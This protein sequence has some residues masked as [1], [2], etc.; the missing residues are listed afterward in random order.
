LLTLL[1]SDHS[2]EVNNSLTRILP[3]L[4]KPLFR[5]LPLIISLMAHLIFC[6]AS[7]LSGSGPP[8]TGEEPVPP[9]NPNGG[10]DQGAPQQA[11]GEDIGIVPLIV[12]LFVVF[13]IVLP[14]IRRGGGGGCLLPF[15]FSGGGVTFGGGGGGFRGGGFG[16]GGG[17][18]GGGGGFG[19]G[20]ASG[21]W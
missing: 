9:L 11:R 8:E 10:Q 17:F 2:C 14:M 6:S 13:F 12:I 4:K 16:G 7:F 18:S 1:S 15:L 20:G 5:Y 21:G 3:D 19:G